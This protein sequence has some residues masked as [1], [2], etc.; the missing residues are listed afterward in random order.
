MSDDKPKLGQ[1]RRF[2]VCVQ[3]S[4]SGFDHILVECP[5]KHQA[6]NKAKSKADGVVKQARIVTS[7]LKDGSEGKFGHGHLHECSI[8]GMAGDYDEYGA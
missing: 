2:E 5:S 3:Y 1:W 8:N 4:T 7:V 6:L